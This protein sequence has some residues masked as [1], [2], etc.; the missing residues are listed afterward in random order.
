[1]V[2]NNQMASK[3]EYERLKK[4]QEAMKPLQEKMMAG[5]QGMGVCLICQNHIQAMKQH[6]ELQ[7]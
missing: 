7:K 2:E 5:M 1:M 3:E 4:F 6:M